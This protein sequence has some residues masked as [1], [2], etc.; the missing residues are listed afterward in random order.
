MRDTHE[1]TFTAQQIAAACTK[2]ADYYFDEMNLATEKFQNLLKS[3][4]YPRWNWLLKSLHSGL[5]QTSRSELS[6]EYSPDIA[7]ML[8]LLREIERNEKSEA[9]CR[10]Y[11]AA[12]ASQQESKWYTLSYLDVLFF[13]LDE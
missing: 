9:E 12:Y 6:A 10:K 1:F 7:T 2:K 4:T 3:F 5:G 11:A 13:G 8:D